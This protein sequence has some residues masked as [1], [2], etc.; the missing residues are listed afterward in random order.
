[1]ATPGAETWMPCSGREVAA[2]CI[3]LPRLIQKGRRLLEG[4][5]AGKDLLWPYLFG[6]HDYMDAP[7]LR[8]LRT[9]GEEVL[10]LLREEPL[11]ERAAAELVQRSGRSAAECAAWSARFRRREGW[12]LTMLDADEGRRPPGRVTSLLRLALNALIVPPA[13]WWYRWRGHPLGLT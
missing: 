10:Q 3:W 7:T 2:G 6:D 12:L 8:F 5:A 1:M 4:E 9:H 13:H 11:D